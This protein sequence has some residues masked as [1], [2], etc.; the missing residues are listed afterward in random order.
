MS[1]ISYTCYVKLKDLPSLKIMSAMSVCSVMDHDSCLIGLTC[2]EVT[3]GKSQFRQAFI[4][5]KKIQKELGI[6]S[7]Y[8]NYII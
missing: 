6:G 2:G 3:I 5:C 8:N 1:C 4:V 7:I